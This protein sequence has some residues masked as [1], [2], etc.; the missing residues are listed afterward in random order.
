[1]RFFLCMFFLFSFSFSNIMEIDSTLIRDSKKA[2]MW[3]L[4]PIAS[5][6]QIYNQKYLKSLLFISAQSYSLYN[7]Y[8]Y[9][10]SNNLDSI[11]KRNKNAWWFLSI[12][13]MS[14]I[15]S[16]VDAELSSFPRRNN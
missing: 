7:V 13:F 8:H 10:Q 9:N 1:M 15:D 12:Y 4:I 11:K 16:Y 6:G 5:Q 14:I 2:L 3:S